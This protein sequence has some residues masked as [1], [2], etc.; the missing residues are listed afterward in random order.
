MAVLHKKR[1]ANTTKR[2][3]VRLGQGVCVLCPAVLALA[4]GAA[5]VQG[6]AAWPLLYAALGAAV[7]G[8]VCW[9]VLRAR[10]GILQSGIEGE[11][12]AVAVLKGLPYEYH[13]V[14]NPVY[15][16][17]GRTA[18]LDAVV[19]SANGVCIVET[20]SHAG[21]ITGKPGDEWWTQ[22]KRGGVKH[23]KNPLLQIQ[24]QQEILQ[25]LLRQ[26]G[27]ACP[28]RAVVF[29]SNKNARVSVRDGR[30]CI[31]AEALCRAVRGGRAVLTPAQVQAVVKCLT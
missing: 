17:G 3:L 7:A 18:E 30:I 26:A 5:A 23:M 15:H 2:A 22:T 4:W 1:N 28:V 20:K 25:A 16:V 11:R 27:L 14:A 6:K 31:G 29:F 9:R 13:V 8:A 21:V 10:A 19:V 12:H 24:R